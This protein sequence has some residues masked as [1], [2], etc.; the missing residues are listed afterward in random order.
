MTDG[1]ALNRSLNVIPSLKCCRFSG[2][3]GK[4]DPA[5]ANTEAKPD[6]WLKRSSIRGKLLYHLMRCPGWQR[7]RLTDVTSGPPKFANLRVEMVCGDSCKVSLVPNAAGVQ[8]IDGVSRQLT[9]LQHQQRTGFMEVKQAISTVN[10]TVRKYS[11]SVSL[12]CL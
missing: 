9:S 7:Q 1:T 11:V 10:T 2:K 6:A 5:P 4:E 12:P 3:F 8:Q